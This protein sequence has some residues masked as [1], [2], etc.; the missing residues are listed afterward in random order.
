MEAALATVDEQI[1]RRIDRLDASYTAQFKYTGDVHST[2]PWP[3][4]IQKQ[5]EVLKR[6]MDE[7][8]K[9]IERMK[10]ALSTP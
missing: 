6:L 5:K 3:A 1:K 7:R 9:L 8:S 2:S 4:A 10:G